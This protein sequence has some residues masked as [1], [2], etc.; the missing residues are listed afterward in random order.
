MVEGGIWWVGEGGEGRGRDD[1]DGGWGL[2]VVLD[3]KMVGGVFVHA[4]GA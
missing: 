4:R 2:V 3:W 1:G